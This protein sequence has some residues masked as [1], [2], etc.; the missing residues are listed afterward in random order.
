MTEFRKKIS[1]LFLFL[2]GIL[3]G[4]LWVLELLS[5]PEW[6]FISSN[7]LLVG[8]GIFAIKKLP[9]YCRRMVPALP[10]SDG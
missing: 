2:L 3:W 7:A 4:Y 8:T 10:Q 6:W 1:K 5:C 9:D